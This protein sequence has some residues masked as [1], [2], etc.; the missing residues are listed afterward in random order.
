MTAFAVYDVFTDTPFGGNQLAVIPDARGLPEDRLQPIAREFNF[1]ETVFLYPGAGAGEGWRARI[2]TP[3]MEVPFAGHPVIGAGVALA[4]MGEGPEL[5]LELG[6]GPVRLE[7]ADGSAAFT[8]SRPLDILDEVD[9]DLVARA[10]SLSPEHIV[11][12]PVKAGVGLDF[13]LVELRDREALRA[14]RPVTEVFREG[15]ER[16]PSGLDFALYPWVR[17]ED[18]LHARMFAPLDGIPED[19]ATGSAAAALAA[20]LSRDG[21][22]QTVIRQGDD[23]GRPSRIEVSTGPAGVRVA[24]RAVRTMDGRLLV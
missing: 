5:T 23:M 14:C 24:G 6:I 11:G 10:L 3:G 18:A 17:G 7:L 19:P 20:L 22:L 12:Q 4:G 8:V 16:H 13:V 15:A 21:P 1:S 9:P 2:F